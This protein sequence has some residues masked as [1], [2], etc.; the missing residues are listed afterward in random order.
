MK[1]FLL[2]LLAASA[3]SQVHADPRVIAYF[4]SGNGAFLEQ[5]ANYVYTHYVVS[6]LLP[7]PSTNQL[8]FD[9]IATSMYGTTI[10]TSVAQGIRE[11]Q[12]GGKKVILA[13][14]GATVGSS[15]YATLNQNIP[16]L[17]SQI[18]GFVKNP[19]A[20]DGLPLHFDG[21]DIDWEDTTAFSNPG[22]AGYSGVD[23]LIDLT[24]ELRKPENLP[25][26]GGWSLSHA[27]QPPYLSDEFAWS[28]GGIGGYINVLNAQQSNIDWIDMQ[29]YNN[30]G[31][32][33]AEQALDNYHSIVEG[34]TGVP[35]IPDFIG[36]P[37]SKLVVGKP[38]APNDAGSGYMPVGQFISSILDPLSEEYGAN[39][40]GAF[41]W[42][43]TSDTNGAWGAAVSEAIAI[44]EPTTI[45]LVA[46]ASLGFLLFRRNA[47]PRA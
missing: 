19:V 16:A 9:A 45:A 32:V 35:G 34:W 17:A 39:F 21:I 40:G 33:T 8:G 31:F 24:S 4:N 47:S 13:F 15:Q 29:Y 7:D 41:G 43:L 3:I 46:I 44:P 14:G 22:T 5:A 6:F 1:K 42:Q 20:Q 2:S 10:T 28:S 38:I 25:S 37:S 11:A 36:L 26:S 12:A 30:P 18:A 23:F 27:P